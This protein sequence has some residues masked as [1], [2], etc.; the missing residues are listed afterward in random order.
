MKFKLL[1]ALLLSTGLVINANAV[2]STNSVPSV[3]VENTVITVKGRKL[4]TSNN[5]F[6]ATLVTEDGQTVTLQS[7]VFKKG[8]KARITLPDIPDTGSQAYKVTLNL[9][10]GNVDTTAPQQFVVIL[11][12]QPTS[13]STNV[14][15]QTNSAQVPDN[16]QSGLFSTQQTVEG[17]DGVDGIQGPP[18]PAGPRGLTG[19]AGAPGPKGD[20]GPMGVGG[21]TMFASRDYGP[22]TWY[23]DT[24]ENETDETLRLKVPNAV[25]VT[26]GN[27]G[28]GW[29]TLTIGSYN[30]CYQGTAPNNTIVAKTFTLKKIVSSAVACPSSGGAPAAMVSPLSVPLNVGETAVLDVNGGGCSSSGPNANCTYTGVLIPHIR[31]TPS[32]ILL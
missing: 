11:N 1:F 30:V 32:S 17:E 10:G 4:N 22:S 31:V 18:G 6:T 21:L 2:V 26:S 28:S 25:S 12:S 5:P 9:S 13:F 7:E 27:S 16:A 8:R 29:L 20:Q 14:D 24:F 3:V 15:P 19:D 23:P